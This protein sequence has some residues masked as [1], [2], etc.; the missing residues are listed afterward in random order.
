MG[1]G[2]EEREKIKDAFGK[3]VNKEIAERVLRGEVALGGE[4]KEVAIFFSDIRNFTSISE[5][6]EPEEVV[7]FLNEYMTRMVNCVNGTRG[8]VDKFMGD[9]IMAV[10]GAPVSTG[11]DTEHAIDAALAMRRELLNFN[12][13]R[14]GDKK[15]VINIGCGINTG[16]VLAG[17]IGSEERMEYTVIGDAVNL[18]SRIESLNKPFGTDIL[19]SEDSYRLVKE[20]YQVVPMQKITVKGKA[21]PQQIFA[22]LGRKDDTSAP[23]TIDELRT[24]LGSKE[25]PFRRRR[26][27]PPEEDVKYEILEK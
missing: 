21:D 11:N 25:Q 16:S 10:W 14:G 27:D 19:I 23:K 5:K 15:P 8:V 9:A 7:E 26:D 3:F 12:A 13:G 20:I 4:R 17:Q 1:Q 2:L 18:A 22:V 6:L 24:I